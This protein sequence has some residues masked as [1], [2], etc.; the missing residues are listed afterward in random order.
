[1][2]INQVNYPFNGGP[3][4]YYFINNLS[5]PNPP[6]T[7]SM[8]GDLWSLTSYPFPVIHLTGVAVLRMI[9]RCKLISVSHPVP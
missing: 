9:P 6:V 7:H 4:A 1:M 5:F 2:F 3:A 8:N